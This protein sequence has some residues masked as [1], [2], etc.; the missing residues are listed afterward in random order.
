MSRLPSLKRCV[1]Q[2]LHG[3]NYY[4]QL[5]LN[6]HAN[7]FDVDYAGELVLSRLESAKEDP[8]FNPQDVARA[9][10]L[11]DKAYDVLIN[12]QTK[13][14]YDEFLSR[15]QSGL[16]F[17]DLL[18]Y[19]DPFNDGNIVIS[20]DI[21]TYEG[22]LFDHDCDMGLSELI[23]DTTSHNTEDLHEN[24]S[25]L[26]VDLPEEKL[27]KDDVLAKARELFQLHNWEYAV[28]ELNKLAARAISAEWVTSED[29]LGDSQLITIL[30]DVAVEIWA[31]EDTDD[32]LELYGEYL[33]TLEGTQLVNIDSINQSHDIKRLVYA[34]AKSIWKDLGFHAGPARY[35]H[36][37]EECLEYGVVG[38][39]E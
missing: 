36:F 30:Q 3:T 13:K 1:D 21:I 12:P 7:R 28:N 35:T 24:T 38:R 25:E 39:D 14:E 26:D 22:P 37:L 29:F 8:A 9:I 16:S 19:Q 32:A 5:G 15:Q 31:S 27:H 11:T 10:Q 33:Q 18:S 4:H 6:H 20:K 2:A 34:Q 23:Q 17:Q